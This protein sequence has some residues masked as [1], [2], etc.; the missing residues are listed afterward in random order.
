MDS[1][2]VPVLVD[3]VLELLAPQPGE[4][5]VDCT[6]GRGGHARRLADRIGPDGLLLGLDVDP[7]NLAAAKARLADAP[8]TVRLFHANFA[9]L[10]EVLE[11]AE[12]PAVDCILAD[13]G[14]ASSQLDDPQRGLSFQS[15]GP[16]DMRL[17]P[18]IDRSAADI[19]NTM[20]EEELANVIFQL[21]QERFS[22]KIAREICRRRVD[23]RIATTEELSAIVCSA[24]RVD[25]QSRKSKIHPATRTFMALRMAVNE[26]MESLDRLL[27]LIPGALCDGGRVAIISFHSLEDRRVKRSFAAA[28]SDGAY[29]ILTRKPIQAKAEEVAENPRSRSA[30]LRAAIKQ[31]GQS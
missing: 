3:D 14:I 5:V 12:R 22:R 28:A 13:L 19:V 9:Q 1:S 15:P 4:V 23:H 2:H 8:P 29:Q 27:E 7:E 31:P 18:R 10:P 30:K 16:L 17:D 21:G 25:P 11:A 26:E 24:L 6:V 20:G